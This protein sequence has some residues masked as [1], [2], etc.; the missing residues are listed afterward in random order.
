MSQIS[1]SAVPAVESGAESF[2]TLKTGAN[3][4][5]SKGYPIS[6]RYLDKVMVP[7][8]GLGVKPNSIFGGRNLYR[9]ETLLAWTRSRSIENR[10]A[11]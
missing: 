1:A 5:T 8:S 2:F 11:A 10:V 7:G 6:I 4:L 3:F 9:A